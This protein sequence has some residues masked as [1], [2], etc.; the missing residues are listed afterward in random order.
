VCVSLSLPPSL[1]PSLSQVYSRV[2]PDFR[3]RNPP[4]FETPCTRAFV[5][6]WEFKDYEEH[7]RPAVASV[8]DLVRFYS[9]YYGQ[10]SF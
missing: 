2:L 6:P 8:D 4:P 7:P 10:T 9:S 5:F 3:A 1:P